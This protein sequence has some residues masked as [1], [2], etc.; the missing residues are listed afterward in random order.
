MHATAAGTLSGSLFNLEKVLICPEVSENLL[1]VSR[2]D[3]QGLAILFQNGTVTVGRHG[4]L[5]D[6]LCSGIR[7]KD[8]YYLDFPT[9]SSANF[10]D[11]NDINVLHR[12]F[13]HVNSASLRKIAQDGLVS[14]LSTV[15]GTM[16]TC[17]PCL[18]GKAKA[19]TPPKFSAKRS[20]RP[21]EI[22]HSDVCGPITPISHSGYRYF[23][24]FTDDF[25]RY[26]TVYLL[27]NKS[28]VFT[29]FQ[30]YDAVLYN[31]FSRH[32]RI[33]RSDN[34]LEYKNHYFDDYCKAYG[35]HQQ[36]TTPYSPNQ[37]GVAE[38]Q[39]YT[40][41]N[42]VRAM[43]IQSTL[44][45]SFWD[46]A[47]LNACYTR[48]RSITQGNNFTKTP[49]EIFHGHL[50]SVKHLQSFGSSCFALTNPYERR[51]SNSVKLTDR[52]QKCIF[53]GYSLNSKSFRLLTSANTILLA[54]FEN[55]IFSN[56]EPPVNPALSAS[57]SDMS[58][59]PISN[60]FAVL[61]DGSSDDDSSSESSSTDDFISASSNLDTD[62]IHE[63][64][65]TDIIKQ[66]MLGESNND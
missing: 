58:S 27:K 5:R 7:Q 9:K 66:E 13:N 33:I 55:V 19:G 65:E 62:L 18:L 32:S 14:D 6:T 34:G 54:K 35:I 64:H 31:M 24:T 45:K 61:D 51:L 59:L 11:S 40:L 36:Y 12:K 43:L 17:E 46:E 52:A 53:L 60:P 49:F 22:I 15:T 23:V 47:L 2:L 28:E 30:E 21:G 29:K 44:A 37:N 1:S 56:I 20:S 57:H 63:E 41:L 38:R 26:V 16:D 50:P 25:S 4:H 10:I 39:N 48:N 3:F 42:P 8:S